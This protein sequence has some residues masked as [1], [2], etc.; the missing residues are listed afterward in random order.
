MKRPQKTVDGSVIY[1]FC[2]I[3]ELNLS[4]KITLLWTI[5][6]TEITIIRK[7]SGKCRKYSENK[8]KKQIKDKNINYIYRK[9]L[10]AFRKRNIT[11][12]IKWWRGK[13]TESLL[14]REQVMMRILPWY[15]VKKHLRASVRNNSRRRRKQTVNTDPV[16]QVERRLSDWSEDQ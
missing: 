13:V 16:Y 5:Q 4:E 7:K 8:Q 12:F 11:F 1:I 2:Y 15:S 6:K 3:L 14:Y 10:T 9:M